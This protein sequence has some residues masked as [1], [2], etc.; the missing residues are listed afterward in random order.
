M[1]KCPDCNKPTKLEGKCWSCIHKEKENQPLHR[2]IAEWSHL[3][4]KIYELRKFRM[5]VNKNP[6]KKL[7]GRANKFKRIIAETPRPDYA[8]IME[9]ERQKKI[10]EEQK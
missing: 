2:L 6:L 10:R 8:Q 7:Q 9:H 5:S 3:E 1:N 4:K